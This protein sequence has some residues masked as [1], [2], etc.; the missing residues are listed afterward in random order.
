[1]KY[2]S[3]NLLVPSEPVQAYTGI[4]LPLLSGVNYEDNLVKLPAGG[5]VIDLHEARLVLTLHA[6]LIA[7]VVQYDVIYQDIRVVLSSPFLTLP[8]SEVCVTY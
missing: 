6:A 5:F 7:S 4:A 8:K 2:G 1:M 3:L